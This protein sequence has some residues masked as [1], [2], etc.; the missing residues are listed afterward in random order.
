MY[1]YWKLEQKRGH[2]IKDKEL[3]LQFT[4]DAESSQVDISNVKLT[5][6]WE[7]VY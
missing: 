3:V 7:P 4:V 6:C 1:A 2:H 5:V